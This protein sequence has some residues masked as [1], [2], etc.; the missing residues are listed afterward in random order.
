MRA[1][2]QVQQQRADEGAGPALPRLHERECGGAA[3]RMLKVL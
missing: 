3:A 2:H 1:T